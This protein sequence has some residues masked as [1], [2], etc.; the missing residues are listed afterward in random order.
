MEKIGLVEREVSPRNARASLV[1]ITSVGEKIFG[2]ASVTLKQKSAV[3]VYLRNV[4]TTS[5]H[6]HQPQ[7]QIP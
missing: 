1:K 3:F 4:N 2:D 6:A 7:F 5:G